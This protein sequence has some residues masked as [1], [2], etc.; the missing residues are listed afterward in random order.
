MRIEFA[1]LD[2]Q[3]VPGRTSE[4]PRLIAIGGERL[5]QARDLNP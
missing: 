4:Q 2:P 3:Q 5:S 1:L